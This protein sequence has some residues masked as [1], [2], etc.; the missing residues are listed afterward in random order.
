MK[1]NEFAKLLNLHPVDASSGFTIPNSRKLFG[2]KIN[3]GKNWSR[4]QGLVKKAF[5]AHSSNQEELRTKSVH[6]ERKTKKRVNRPKMAA[7]VYKHKQKLLVSYQTDRNSVLVTSNNVKTVTASDDAQMLVNKEQQSN[8][9]STS[10]AVSTNQ[11]EAM[12]DQEQAAVTPNSVNTSLTSTSHCE[13]ETMIHQE[14]EN[15]VQPEERTELLETEST[16]LST[17]KSNTEC[18]ENLISINEL[19]TQADLVPQKTELVQKASS[20]STI[21]QN[22]TRGQQP[23]PVTEPVLLPSSSPSTHF[24]QRPRNYVH[25]C[26]MSCPPNKLFIFD[27]QPAPLHL[28]TGLLI[29]YRVIL[30]Q[31]HLPHPPTARL[32]RKRCLHAIDFNSQS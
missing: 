27:P 14:D 31:C 23:L 30:G 8:T 6:A 28:P 13:I 16:T 1:L 10:T 25:P 22:I 19:P 2:K 15:S 9:C 26:A 3:Y 5:L 21:D 7:V 11:N 17:G 18:N 12:A 32:P 4:K 29:P 20:S 24:Y